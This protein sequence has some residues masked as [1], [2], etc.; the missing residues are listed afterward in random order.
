[1]SDVEEMFFD[2]AVGRSALPV[3]TGFF[4]ILENAKFKAVLDTAEADASAANKLK[5]T[6]RGRRRVM[7][8]FLMGTPEERVAASSVLSSSEKVKVTELKKNLFDPLFNRWFGQDSTRFFD[9]IIP[10][11]RT[12][13]SSDVHN[14]FAGGAAP[15][16]ADILRFASLG[17]MI[18]PLERDLGRMSASVIRTG[19]WREHVDAPFRAAGKFINSKA[20]PQEIKPMLNRYL[21]GLQGKDAMVKNLGAVYKKFFNALGHDVP[22]SEVTNLVTSYVSLTHAGLLGLRMGPLVRNMFAGPTVSAPRIGMKWYVEGMR[23]SRTVQGKA[24]FDASGIAGEQATILDKLREVS[25]GPVSTLTHKLSRVTMRPYSFVDQIP[26]AHAYLGMRARILDAVKRLPRNATDHE[27]YRETALYRFHPVQRRQIKDLWRAG[28]ISEAANRGGIV[29]Q[30]DTQ[31]VYRQ[32]F[33]PQLLTSEAGRLLGQFGIWPLN[34]MEYFGQ[35][36]KGLLY[37]EVWGAP[38]QEMLKWFGEWAASNM[39]VIAAFGTAGA[40]V[41]MGPSALQHTLGWTVGGP[42]FGGG[43]AL[44][45]WQSMHGMLY[46]MSVAR[47]GEA[48]GRVLRESEN[49]IPGQG[50]VRDIQKSKGL[51]GGG[52]T[53]LWSKKSRTFRP[54]KTTAEQAFRILTGAHTR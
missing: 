18:N 12:A 52:V 19:F 31:W 20:I 45:L 50:F 28:N 54:S 47:P 26:R 34:Y 3:R 40:A 53:N 37:P 46:E 7:G 38:R 27:F 30:Q 25:S 2:P 23:Q 9:E 14:V 44:D 4:D 42:L 41:G 11:M 49:L 5:W 43:P 51:G 48:T 32:G 21:H 13:D 1:M 16:E 29:A 17:H 8:D 15:G 22:E 6:T 10:R 33:R 24:L 35:M 36:G 39:A